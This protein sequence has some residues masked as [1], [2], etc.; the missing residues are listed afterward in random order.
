MGAPRGTLETRLWRHVDKSGSCWLWQAGVDSAGYGQLR[1]ESGRLVMAHRAS[2]ELAHGPIPPGQLVCHAC[3]TPRCVNPAHL[4][5]GTPLDN[6]VDM[7]AKGRS[8]R[9]DA[10][11]ARLYPERRPRG[12]RHPKAR[13]TEAQVV[14]LRQ[15]YAAGTTSQRALAREY[16]VSRATIV[17]A[18]ERRSWHHVD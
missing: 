14:D 18:L 9:G 13:L 3:D 5:L 1:N 4:F 17:A 2:Y 12:A 6:A 8:A 7:V 11:S 15:R 10:S 16:G